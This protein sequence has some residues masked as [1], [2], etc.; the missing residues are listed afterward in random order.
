[1]AK[2]YFV[3]NLHGTTITGSKA[4]DTIDDMNAALSAMKADPLIAQIDVQFS[5]TSVTVK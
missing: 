5:Q 4:V 2:I 1:M 3:A